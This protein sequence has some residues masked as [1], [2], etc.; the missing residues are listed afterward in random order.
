MEVVDKTPEQLRH[1]HDVVL[2]DVKTGDVEAGSGCV[3]GPYPQSVVAGLLGPEQN[4]VTDGTCHRGGR[5][6]RRTALQSGNLTLPPP[7]AICSSGGGP[8][9][10]VRQRSTAHARS[11][12]AILAD[13]QEVFGGAGDSVGAGGAGSSAS[14][15]G[16]SPPPSPPSDSSPPPPS[17]GGALLCR[18]LI[19]RWRRLWRGG[20]WPRVRR[21]RRRRTRGRMPRR[22]TLHGLPRR[23]DKLR[24]GD[25]PLLFSC[26]A[27]NNRAWTHTAAIPRDARVIGGGICPSHSNERNRHGRRCGRRYDK[28]FLIPGVP[29]FRSPL[30]PTALM[31]RKLTPS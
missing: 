3:A 9:P 15:V 11:A 28:Q 1:D 2:Q 6:R 25:A 8:N 16:R 5:L 4:P 20:R 22:E 19:R 23:T 17:S 12:A 18:W 10:C 26:I 7:P 29:H 24:D 21:R 31:W 30:V 27:T 13:R 14:G